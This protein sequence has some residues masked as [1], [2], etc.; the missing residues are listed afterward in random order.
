MCT[1]STFLFGT[2]VNWLPDTSKQPSN[3]ICE[4]E[5]W[6]KVKCM[7]RARVF[8]QSFQ[9]AKIHGEE[10]SDIDPYIYCSLHNGNVLKT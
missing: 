1:T 7:R 3:K 10:T 4:E 5:N 8:L 2:R 9:F 6:N